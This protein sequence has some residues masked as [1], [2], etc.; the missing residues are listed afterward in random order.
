MA[1]VRVSGD[2]P[3]RSLVDFEGSQPQNTACTSGGR[4]ASRS[5]SQQTAAQ[6]RGHVIGFSS[7]CPLDHEHLVGNTNHVASNINALMY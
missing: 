6:G 3:T 2:Q 7:S 4:S 1:L 5:T